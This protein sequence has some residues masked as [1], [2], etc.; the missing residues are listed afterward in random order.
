[1]LA[2]PYFKSEEKVYTRIIRARKDNETTDN[3]CAQISLS[4]PL[5]SVML[6]NWRKSANVTLYDKL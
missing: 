3:V 1:M 6:Q 2:F 4:T 5:S